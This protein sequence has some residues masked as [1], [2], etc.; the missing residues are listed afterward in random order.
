MCT[1]STWWIPRQIFLNNSWRKELVHR[2]A[3]SVDTKADPETATSALYKTMLDEKKFEVFIQWM[4]REFSSEAALCFIE[5]AQF[6]ERLVE[7]VMSD[8]N[9]KQSDTCNP[10]EYGG[11]YVNVF[12]EKMPKSDIVFGKEA[13]DIEIVFTDDDDSGQKD[14]DKEVEGFKIMARILHNKYIK[15]YGEFEVNIASQL[16]EKYMKIDENNWNMD[17]HKMIHVFDEVMG[18]MFFFM[19]QSFM[20]YQRSQSP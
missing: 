10:Q 12:Y 13:D 20:R 17:I 16:R 19:R 4:Y 5:L 7:Y 6:K 1:L 3:I 2:N 14:T 15:R 8:T 11:K 18:E 9:T